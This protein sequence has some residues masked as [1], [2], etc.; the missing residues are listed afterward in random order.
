[1]LYQENFSLIYHYVYRS[2]K[3]R[4]EAEDLTSAIFLKAL[5]KVDQ[6]R[7]PKT[8]QYWLFQ[9]MRTTLADYWRARSQD[10]TYS[11]EALLETGW[12]VSAEEPT[13]MSNRAVECVQH[14]LKALPER[15]RE[16]LICRF[17][18]N[19]SVRDTALK[20]G[21]TEV[22]VKVVQFRALKRAAELTCIAVG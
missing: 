11:L 2:V 13:T 20:M 4:E 16:V 19:L 21:M 9:V 10:V 8:M 5:S 12:E 14:L 3:N 6:K 17:L 15:Y 1:M 7:D 18:L 22:N